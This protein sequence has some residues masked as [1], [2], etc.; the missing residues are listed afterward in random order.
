MCSP[1]DR[2]MLAECTPYVHRSLPKIRHKLAENSPY[3]RSMI[4]VCSAIKRTPKLSPNIRQLF[5]KQSPNYLRTYL[6]PKGIGCNIQFLSATDFIKFA[7]FRSPT[8]ADTADILSS[9]ICQI[10]CKHPNFAPKSDRELVAR[11]SQAQC[12]WGLSTVDSSF[13]RKVLFIFQT[14]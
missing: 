1:D 11:C 3:A 13:K 12:D 14:C 10:I 9:T 7:Y 5:A 8:N 6:S 2:H 4:A